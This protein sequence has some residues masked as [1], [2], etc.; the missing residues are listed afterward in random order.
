MLLAIVIYGI[1][2]DGSLKKGAYKSLRNFSARQ[3][4]VPPAEAPRQVDAIAGDSRDS[5]T[6]GESEIKADLH[7]DACFLLSKI[8]SENETATPG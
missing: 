7:A 8:Q 2:N 1:I 4:V 6:V 3:F 5:D